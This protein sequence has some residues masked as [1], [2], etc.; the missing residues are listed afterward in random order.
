MS[1]DCPNMEV[2]NVYPLLS[3]WSM[4]DK[5]ISFEFVVDFPF[6]KV[7]LKCCTSNFKKLEL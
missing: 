4:S 5:N 1:T 3:S 6:S 7:Y 2:S